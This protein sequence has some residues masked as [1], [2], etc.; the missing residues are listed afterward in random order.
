M[1]SATNRGSQAL[2]EIR[3]TLYHGHTQFP[4]AV[5]GWKPF[6][7]SSRQQGPLSI[8]GFNHGLSIS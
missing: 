8:T 1:P 4:S 2:V 7:H 6:G 3:H 5:K